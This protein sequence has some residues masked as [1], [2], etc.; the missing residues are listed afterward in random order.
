MRKFFVERFYVHCYVVDF[1]GGRYR[2]GKR[3]KVFVVVCILR[4]HVDDGNWDYQWRHECRSV[5]ASVFQKVLMLLERLIIIERYRGNTVSQCS[6]AGSFVCV[7][8]R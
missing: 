7:S 8:A 5:Y 6:T 2:D 4:L 1:S 3:E